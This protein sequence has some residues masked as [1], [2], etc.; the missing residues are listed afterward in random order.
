[1]DENS[2]NEVESD[3]TEV[4]GYSDSECPE[5]GEFLP[6]RAIEPFALP[7]RSNGLDSETICG[8]VSHHF[9]ERV[10]VVCW[11]KVHS[12]RSLGSPSTRSAMMFC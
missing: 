1:M 3:A 11:L 5:G 10:L 6:E 9:D 2:V 8:K 4:F 7:E 12:Q